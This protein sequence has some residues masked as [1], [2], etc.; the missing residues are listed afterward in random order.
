MKIKVISICFLVVIVWSC[1]KDD[2]DTTTEIIEEVV[3]SEEVELYDSDK[4]EN[5]LVL[6]VINGGTYSFLIDKT[7]RKLKEWNF[8]NNLGNDLVIL[9]SGKLLGIFKPDG[10]L[11]F[12]FGGYGGVIK[13]INT[14]GSIDWEFDYHSST[15]LAH[16]DIEILPNGNVLIL[17]WEKVVKSEVQ[18]YGINAVDDVYPEML[19]EVNPSSNAIIWEWHSKDHFVQ[20]IDETLPNYGIIADNP[21]LINP[22]YAL[23]DNGDIMH[24]NGIDY[25]PEKDVIFLS[26][27]FFSEVWV[28]DHSTTITE[29]STDV[30]GNYGKGGDLIYRFGN[31]GAYNNLSGTRLFDNNHFPNFLE[32]NEPG[33]GNILIFNNGASQGQSIIYELVMPTNYN[34]V[35][36]SDNEPEVAWSFT[37]EDLFNQRISGAV[38]LKNGNTLIC[39]GDYGFWEVTRE[40]EIVWKYNKVGSF[41]RAYN[42]LPTDSA[43]LNLGL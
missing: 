26:I 12:S 34:L 5:S 19:I 3:L 6:G 8:E 36:N 38:R 11:E 16:H 40:K 41:W 1:N 29:A 13:I 10:D 20:D 30:G 2:S 9:P 27:N 14:D 4:L 39:E 24:G 25:D 37:H 28:I 15:Y 31:P 23:S 43:I 21:Q 32:S 42:Y 7:G 35:P 18:S 17:V 22:N 33:A